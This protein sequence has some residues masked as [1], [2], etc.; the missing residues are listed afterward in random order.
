M[1]GVNILPSQSRHRSG[2]QDSSN[3]E[4]DVGGCRTGRADLLAVLGE[5]DPRHHVADL[6]KVHRPSRTE[7]QNMQVL[8]VRSLGLVVI[9]SFPQSVGQLT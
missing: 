2:D 6:D 8:R 9:G 5:F 3:A 4:A 7:L 1:V